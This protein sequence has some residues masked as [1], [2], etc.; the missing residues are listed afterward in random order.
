MALHHP[1]LNPYTAVND[2]I[3]SIIML[4]A[5]ATIVKFYSSSQSHHL[6]FAVDYEKLSRQ[7]TTTE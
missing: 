3:I 4:L 6:I 2:A 5:L 7:P 1:L